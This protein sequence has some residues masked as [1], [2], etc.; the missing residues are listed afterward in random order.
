MAQELHFCLTS[1]NREAP[2]PQTWHLMSSISHNDCKTEMVTLFASPSEGW[3]LYSDDE[4]FIGHDEHVREGTVHISKFLSSDDMLRR[5]R[6]GDNIAEEG[7]LSQ[8]GEEVL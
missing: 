2:G 3:K 6:L 5:E 1:P 4:I 8:S 7:V